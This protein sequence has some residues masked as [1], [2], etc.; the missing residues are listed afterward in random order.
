MKRIRLTEGD[1]HQ[2]IKESVKRVLKEGQ[3]WGMLKDTYKNYKKHP[4]DL[5]WDDE[6]GKPWPSKDTVD[7]YIKNG[8]YDA[9]KNPDYY[10]T[11]TGEPA[12]NPGDGRKPINKSIT[13]RLGRRAGY[14]ASK[15]LMTFGNSKLGRTIWKGNK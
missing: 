2:I 10:D 11:E 7:D 4:N 12:Y 8:R 5:R 15:G 1:L 3:G 14:E 13:G 6:E 9:Q